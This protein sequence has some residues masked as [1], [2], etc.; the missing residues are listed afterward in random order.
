MHFETLFFTQ[1]R[2]SIE[3]TDG[4]LRDNLTQQIMEPSRDP[5]TKERYFTNIPGISDIFNHQRIS[6]GLLVL[7]GK[8]K[9]TIPEYHWYR[10]KAVPINGN[11]AD[12]RVGNLY[13]DYVNGPIESLY[14]PGYYY[15]PE[16]SGILVNR[17]CKVLSYASGVS[18]KR[19]ESIA[20]GADYLEISA[21]RSDGVLRSFKIHILMALAFC[22]RPGNPF[23]LT[24]NHIDLNTHN[25]EPANL[26]YVTQEINVFH[27]H[28]FAG[29]YRNVIEIYFADGSKQICDTPYTAADLL[30]IT[31][32]A[33]WKHFR[34]TPDQLLN[35]CRVILMINI[36]INDSTAFNKVKTISETIEPI[37]CKNMETNEVV[38]FPNPNAVA[39][40]LGVSDTGVRVVLTRP[41]GTIYLGRYLLKY[42]SDSWPT[43]EQVDANR[44][45]NAPKI[46]L[47]LEEATGVVSEYPSA[48]KAINAL[49]ESKKVVTVSLRN[50][51][52]R[53]INGRRFMYK[54]ENEA[55]IIWHVV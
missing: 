2:Y 1:G 35:G 28:L 40:A 25:N 51:D 22:H 17:N 30:N 4:K 52:R 45:S 43:Q 47:V 7:L 6:A 14:Y 9:I 24:V 3:Q 18:N 32:A 55:K 44:A 50:N 42:F 37:E 31:P 48:Y 39:S 49:N 41:K 27:Y 16:V 11:I 36:I 23:G 53:L 15:I 54:P 10:L 12:V 20:S 26:E 19:T 33:V 38:T 13:F 29:H 8:Y 5:I 21:K 34:H 46:V